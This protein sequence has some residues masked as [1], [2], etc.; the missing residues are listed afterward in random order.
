MGKPKRK[1]P[2]GKHRRRWEDT[3]STDLLVVE[4]GHR[5]DLLRSEQRQVGALVNAVMN[6]KSSIKR[7]EFLY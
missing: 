7:G 5:L 1:R 2:L 4:W 6:L 3:I